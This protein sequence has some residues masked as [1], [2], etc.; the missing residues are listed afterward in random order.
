MRVRFT[1]GVNADRSHGVRHARNSQYRSHPYA[2][3]PAERTLLVVRVFPLAQGSEIADRYDTKK[4][5][6]DSDGY[7]TSDEIET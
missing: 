7:N 3:S 1:R 2:M 5:A 6:G 4:K